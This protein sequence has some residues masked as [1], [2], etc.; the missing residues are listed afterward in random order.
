MAPIDPS[1]PVSLRWHQFSTNLG[2]T[3]SLLRE[4]NI[5]TDITFIVEEKQVPA[6]RFILA[7]SSPLFLSLLHSS[8]HPHPMVYLRGVSY[9]DLTSLLDFMYQG[10]VKVEQRHLESFLNT[11]ED[12][13]VK[14]LSDSVGDDSGDGVEQGEGDTDITDNTSVNGYNDESRGGK[15]FNEDNSTPIFECLKEI[16]DVKDNASFL[17]D[18]IPTE[19]PSADV[20]ISTSNLQVNKPQQ[21][22]T[23]SDPT[24]STTGKR[25]S[26]KSKTKQVAGKAGKEIIPDPKTPSKLVNKKQLKKVNSPVEELKSLSAKRSSIYGKKQTEEW[27]TSKRKN[28]AE[29]PSSKMITS[30]NSDCKKRKSSIGKGLPT[31]GKRQSR[32]EHKQPKS[33]LEIPEVSDKQ[34]STSASLESAIK[35]TKEEI[36]KL[37]GQAEED[38]LPSLADATD[39]TIAEVEKVLRLSQEVLGDFQYSDNPE[40]YEEVSLNF[41]EE[42]SDLSQNVSLINQSS[43]MKPVSSKSNIQLNTLESSPT[44]SSEN[45]LTPVKKYQPSTKTLSIISLMLVKHSS[46]ATPWKCSICKKLFKSKSSA[47]DHIGLEHVE[48]KLH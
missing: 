47:E 46:N 16:E 4:R 24:S 34:K 36:R 18:P 27:K 42:S 29:N 12:L 10:E 13:K 8:S 28:S 23:E 39:G 33:D 31:G 20:N 5:L 6:H 2:T 26:C 14:G 15:S 21:T 37:E 40:D 43:P 1:G 38:D 30:N 35:A 48:G 44:K 11:A 17:C 41:E 9:R 32:A 22:C 25:R 19:E 45:I 3:S 7:S